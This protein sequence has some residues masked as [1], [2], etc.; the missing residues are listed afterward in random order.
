MKYSESQVKAIGGKRFIQKKKKRILIGLAAGI[1]WIPLLSFLTT[2]IATWVYVA[3]LIIVG[4]NIVW[5][6]FTSRRLLWERYRKNPEILD[7]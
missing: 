2:K 4:V 1:I 7:G 5:S 3:P 6:Y